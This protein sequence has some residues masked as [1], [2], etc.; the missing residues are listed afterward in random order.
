MKKYILSIVLGLT[1]AMFTSCDDF[2]QVDASNQKETAK[3]F[4]TYDELRQATAYLY[5]RPWF[6]FHSTYLFSFG[7]A[8]EIISMGTT[9]MNG[10]MLLSVFLRISR[11][12][13]D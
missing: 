8:V 7:D 6:G 9:T 1:T 4:T 3:A 2:L 13:R 11:I 5:M 10:D 12:L